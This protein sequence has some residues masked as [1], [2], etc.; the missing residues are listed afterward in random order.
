MDR[1]L[2]VYDTQRFLLRDALRIEMVMHNLSH[3]S[4]DI[5]SPYKHI[6]ANIWKFFIGVMPTFELSQYLID[7]CSYAI[8][9]I[10]DQHFFIIFEGVGGNGKSLFFL[11]LEAMLGEYM[12]NFDP[13]MIMGKEKS[14]VNSASPELHR[15]MGKLVAATQEP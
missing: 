3:N 7:M 15:Y 1:A 2:R 8:S 14:G 12:V 5:V 4:I 10:R 11:L 9:G 13:R 6:E